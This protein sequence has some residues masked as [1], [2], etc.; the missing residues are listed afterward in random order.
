MGRQRRRLRLARGAL[1]GMT[2]AHDE[3]LPVQPE[4]RRPDP[5]V[6]SPLAGGG[7]WSEADRRTREAAG[8]AALQQEARRR[9][10]PNRKDL[11]Q[12]ALGYLRRRP[13]D[14]SPTQGVRLSR[15]RR[16]VDSD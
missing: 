12:R 11:I 3:Y 6:T 14:P 2:Q 16:R 7:R 9:V 10:V 1:A 5:L 13:G 8:F 4:R 15:D